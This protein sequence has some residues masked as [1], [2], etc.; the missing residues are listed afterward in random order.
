MFISLRPLK[1]AAKL[2]RLL[3]IPSF[4][5]RFPLPPFLHSGGVEMESSGALPQ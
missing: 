3:D 1:A 4:K 2:L 5:G